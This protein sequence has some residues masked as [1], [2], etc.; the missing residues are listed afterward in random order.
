MINFENVKLESVIV[1]KVGNKAREENITFSDSP[2]TIENDLVKELL[3][4]YFLS[5]FKNSTFYQ[6]FHETDIRFNEVYTYCANIFADFNSFYDNSVHISKHLYEQS[7]HP[8]IKDGEFYLVYLDDCMIDDEI[9]QGIGLFK[10][11]NKE[12]YLKINQ[13]GKNFEIKS[14]DGI[15]INK[16]DKGCIIFNTEKEGGF[17]VA[18]VDSLNK[19]GEALYWKDNFLKIT[20]REDNYFHTKSCINLCKNFIQEVY[21]EENDV[22]RAD[23]I[24]FKNKAAKYFSEKDT[25]N[26]QE[27][28]QEVISQPE[29]INSFREYKKVYEED[30][31]T[32]VADGFEISEMAAKTA[33]KQFK[34]VIKLDTNF[35]IYVHG[36]RELMRKGFDEEKNMNFYQVFFEEEK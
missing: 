15:N 27:F 25:F 19:A 34:S 5:P 17:I 30:F 26:L 13:H 28:E 14:D 31:D 6:F 32:T 24:E 11:E 4:K 7:N 16:L 18:I 36:T 10:T 23:Q 1:H 3:L 20:P 29:A 9:V 35:H 22:E 2:I 12:T 8:K 21:N 33:K